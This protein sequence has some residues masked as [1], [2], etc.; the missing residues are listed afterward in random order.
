MLNAPWS[1]AMFST[2]PP[3]RRARHL[4]GARHRV[5]DR[6]QREHDLVLQRH[7][8]DDARRRHLQ[9]APD[10]RDDGAVAPLRPLV[11]ATVGPVTVGRD[12]VRGLCDH[13]VGPRPAVDRVALGAATRAQDVTGGAADQVVRARA[14]VLV[15]LAAAA[16]E[17][18]AGSAP[19]EVSRARP[20]AQV[21]DVRL[22]VVASRRA[23]R[24]RPP[25]RARL[26]R[27]RCAPSSRR[28]RC[29]RRRSSRRAR[30]AVEQSSPGS[31]FS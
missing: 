10:R 11:D 17:G 28:C 6:A 5:D 14:A 20:A 1:S 13:E 24:R 29:R 9:R 21:L 23:R 8:A 2:R 31:P 30:S 4:D 26:S 3:A 15:V 19:G 22:D 16:V 12:R 25:R 7:T 18:V 27:R